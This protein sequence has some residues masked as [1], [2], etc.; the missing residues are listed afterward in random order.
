[1]MPSTSL[2]VLMAW[3]KTLHVGTV[4]TVLV[5]HVS[6][7]YCITS[8]F[9]SSVAFSASQ[10]QVECGQRV[11][12]EGRRLS[13][14]TCVHCHVRCRRQSVNEWNQLIIKKFVKEIVNFCLWEH[15][16]ALSGTG[17]IAIKIGSRSCPKKVVRV[18]FKQWSELS[19][20]SGY[21]WPKSSLILP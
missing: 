5:I 6:S 18:V 9:F 16:L 2:L 15:Q 21:S 12:M 10:R 1:M 4:H 11:G 14:G 7:I 20:K 8:C 17:W 3:L 19:L 13:S